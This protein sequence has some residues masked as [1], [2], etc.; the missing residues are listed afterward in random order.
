M[1]RQRS[2]IANLLT[3]AVT[4]DQR[5]IVAATDSDTI[6]WELGKAKPVAHVLGGIAGRGLAVSR[7]GRY[8]AT[9]DEKAMVRVR[10]LPDLKEIGRWSLPDLGCR[11]LAC[12]VAFA[13]DN[14]S[15]IIA[16]WE[17]V[18][19]RIALPLSPKSA[20]ISSRELL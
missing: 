9:S 12:A 5:I 7:D 2:G 14:S 11:D 3:A 20:D 1:P 13:P 18:I 15:L 10:T 6:A 4:N 19:R 16:G 17:G 8:L